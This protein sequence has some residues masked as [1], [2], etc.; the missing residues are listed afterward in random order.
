ME[1][2]GKRLQQLAQ[3]SVAAVREARDDFV[4]DLGGAPPSQV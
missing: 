4:S 3:A 1:V 2:G